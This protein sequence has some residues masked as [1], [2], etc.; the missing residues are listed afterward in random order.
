VQVTGHGNAKILACAAIGGDGKGIALHGRLGDRT[1]AR[2]LIRLEAGV[3]AFGKLL[4]HIPDNCRSRTERFDMAAEA[5]IA[6][7]A[8]GVHDDV[9]KLGRQTVEPAHQA[10][11]HDDAGSDTGAKRDVENVVMAP[12]SAKFPLAQGRSVAVIVQKRRNTEVRRKSADQR[13]VQPLRDVRRLQDDAEAGIKGT[14][15]AGADGEDGSALWPDR[16]DKGLKAVVGAGLIRACQYPLMGDGFWIPRFVLSGAQMGPA[17]I[18]CNHY[19][20]GVDY[21]VA[22]RA[23]LAVG[24]H[25]PGD[26]TKA[27]YNASVQRSRSWNTLAVLLVLAVAVAAPVFTS[28]LWDLRVGGDA[29]R[30]GHYQEAARAFESAAHKLLWRADLWEMAGMSAYSGGDQLLA[31]RLLQIASDKDALS[32]AGWEVRGSSLWAAGYPASAVSAWLEGSRQYPRE[33]QLWDRLAGA[34]HELADYEAEQSALEQRLRIA[35]DAAARYRLGLLLMLS[36]AGSAAEALD[37][38]TALNPEVGPAASTLKAALGAAVGEREPAERMVLV[39]RSLG[40]VQEWALA[41]RAFTFAVETDPANAEAHAWLGEA[42]Q[43]LEQDGRADLDAALSLGRNSSV[44]HILRGL[45][46]RRQG[47]LGLSLAEYSRAAQ[48]EPANAAL[49]SLLGEAYAAS[50][51]LVTAL[52]AYQN[53]VE[54]APSKSTYWRLL[55]LFCAD[56]NVQVLDVGVAAGL[57]AVLLAPKDPQALDALGWSYAQ[58]GYL[59]KAEQALQKALEQDPELASAHV[60][61][62]LAY[63]R[64]G[65]N[66]LALEHWRKAVQIDGSGATGQLAAQL[67]ATYFP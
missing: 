8:I 47:N 50:G 10:V 54:L 20:H 48:L 15:G 40:L 43:H 5:A 37:A 27:I 44:V 3:D 24:F 32:A 7:R 66:N 39:G 57:K 64:W 35:D 29:I 28:G 22:A 9:S 38:A 30:A 45:Y 26:P 25:L 65:Q 61:L 6:G 58:A 4:Q 2:L 36:N 34:Y 52:E 46:W 60:H 16:P 67:L 17:D 23:A 1:R 42:R 53:A 31:A 13:E 12:G 59:I 63:L 51:D 33:P 55:A 49:Q 41:A 19:T 18:K 56:N 21:T 11:I 14:R 62:G